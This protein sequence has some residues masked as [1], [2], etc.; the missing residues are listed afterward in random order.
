MIGVEES[1]IFYNHR[2]GV[3]ENRTNSYAS[4]DELPSLSE[5]AL[6]FRQFL[7]SYDSA[8]LARKLLNNVRIGAAVLDINCEAILNCKPL[9]VEECVQTPFCER[10]DHIPPPMYLQQLY[11]ALSLRPLHYLPA[12]EAVCLEEVQRTMNAVH[13]TNPVLQDE[14][15]SIPQI[16]ITLLNTSTK[17]TLIRSLLADIQEKFVVVPGIIIQAGKPIHKLSK[18]TLQCRFCDHKMAVQVPVWRDKPAIPRMCQFSSVA[19]TSSGGITETIDRQRGC[20][21]QMDPYTIIPS[22][23]TYIDVQN[24]RLQELPEDVSI[25]DMP[26]QLHLNASRKLCEK[27]SPG[28]RVFVHGVLTSY[29]SNPKGNRP[30]GTSLTYLHV[31]GYQKYDE[32][33][34][35]DVDFTI[36]EKTYFQNL[37]SSR[38]I[39]EKI[40]NSIAPDI[41]GMGNVKKAAA[42]LLFGGTHLR[43]GDGCRI[44][45]DI[46]VL[47]LGDPSVA[48]S[49][50]LK[51]VNL[52]SPISV[53]T[54]GTLSMIYM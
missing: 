17:T 39:F 38:N 45:G 4:A 42:S 32:G 12:C 26:R 19:N 50:I 23:C 49:Q 41:L 8:I 40:F 10:A 22:E 15:D 1:H 53:Y 33:K 51:Y 52:L 6:F 34:G 54:S 13:P 25:G 18:M 3:T 24:L 44:R 27:M 28:D 31:L 43:G 48:K 5:C 47:L 46:N 16:Q 2:N 36:R 21:G 7:H 14:P 29:D 37:A 30:D 11:K 20:K 9:P 35:D